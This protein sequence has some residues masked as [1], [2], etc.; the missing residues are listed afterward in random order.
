MTGRDEVEQVSLPQVE[1]NLAIH[2]TVDGWKRG[3]LQAGAIFCN[4]VGVAL[5]KGLDAPPGQAQGRAHGQAAVAFDDDGN[6]FATG[7][8]QPVNGDGHAAI[9]TETGLNTL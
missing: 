9:V 8:H 7:A 6:R 2:V 3:G 1:E 4:P 5:D